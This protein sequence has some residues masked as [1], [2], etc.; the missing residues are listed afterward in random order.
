MLDL[1]SH[2]TRLIVNIF[3]VLNFSDKLS[4]GLFAGD[5]G[6]AKT[7]TA[8]D[9]ASSVRSLYLIIFFNYWYHHFLITKESSTIWMWWLLRSD[10]QWFGSQH[11][12]LCL[13]G[14]WSESEM[15][16]LSSIL[17]RL[18]ANMQSHMIYFC[19]W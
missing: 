3:S 14:W 10:S 7:L 8:D 12:S 19:L 13:I 5:F 9:L 1:V 15:A 11:A 4:M 2:C 6:L 17:L 16:R 18:H